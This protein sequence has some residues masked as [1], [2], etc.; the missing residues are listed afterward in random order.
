[1]GRIVG[2]RFEAAAEPE[3]PPHRVHFYPAAM[4]LTVGTR[5][6]VETPQGQRVG[7]VVI[8]PDQVV[9]SELAAPEPGVVERGLGPTFPH[10]PA[11]GPPARARPA[12][13]PLLLPL[14]VDPP[15]HLPGVASRLLYALSAANRQ[16]L[17][18]KHRLPSLGQLVVTPQGPGQVVQVKVRRGSAVVRLAD[19]TLV[20][21]PGEALA[22]APSAGEARAARLPAPEG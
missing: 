17:E 10:A 6:L 9:E 18:R 21:L 20:E 15:A 19:G 11:G 12:G 2:V 13:L 22:A 3:S 4:P 7:R 14:S 16:Y 8:A 5:V 1:M